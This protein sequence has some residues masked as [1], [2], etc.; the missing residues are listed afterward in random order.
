FVFIFMWSPGLGAILTQLITTRSLRGLGWRLGSARWLGIAYLLP[1]VYTLPVY[2][3]TWL[4][5]IGTFS[6]PRLFA[7]IA[8][9]YS[10][11]NLATTVTIILLLEL[12]VGMAENLISGLGEEIGWRG[13][14]VPELAK[15]TSFTKTALISGAVWAAW[16][17]PGIFLAGL[18]GDTPHL[19]AAAMF[20]VLIIAISFPFAWL[21]LKSGS[22]WPA[23]VLHASH[24]LFIYPIFERLTSDTELTPYITGEF[25]VG[26]A[27]TSLVVAYVFWRMQRDTN[28]WKQPVEVQSA[29]QPQ[30]PGAA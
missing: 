22:L 9:K 15:V 25:G 6:N 12:T 13:L 7:S 24:N 29:V 27:L 11:P 21:R 18:S 8:E 3:F 5:G 17:M 28:L 23:A 4:T 20:A 1:V 19:Y 10:S 16:H 14:F 2:A 26:M 30:S